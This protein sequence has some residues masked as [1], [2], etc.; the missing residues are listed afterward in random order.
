M[1]P[2]T[3]SLRSSSVRR[4][5]S[6]TTRCQGRRGGGGWASRCYPRC[7]LPSARA[8]TPAARFLRTSSLAGLGVGHSIMER[9]GTRK[10]LG[11]GVQQTHPSYPTQGP[12]L[13]KS[14]M[15][16]ALGAV[17]RLWPFSGCWPA[18]RVRHQARDDC[19]A[20]HAAGRS[21]GRR[22]CSVVGGGRCAA[23]RRP[24][25]RAQDGPDGPAGNVRTK[26]KEE[27]PNKLHVSTRTDRSNPTDRQI[28]AGIQS[29]T[30]KA[31]QA[32]RHTQANLHETACTQ[33]DRQPD[34]V[35]CAGEMPFSL[36]V[37][38]RSGPQPGRGSRRGAP[39]SAGRR[40]WPPPAP[41]A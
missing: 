38:S 3:A 26:G 18:R 33:A 10:A 4:I 35:L 23:G 22:R 2:A 15:G 28:W 39:S 9:G 19:P 14:P 20:L 31:T 41:P 17:R 40:R 7:F 6:S 34:G 16:V 13:K 1:V 29:A 5:S 12:K 11:G 37:I 25:S 30:Q 36:A 32:E 24:A 27:Q 8:T 21:P